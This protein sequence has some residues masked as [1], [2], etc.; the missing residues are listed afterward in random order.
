MVKRHRRPEDQVN[1][2]LS[3]IGAPPGEKRLVVQG[4]APWKGNRQDRNLLNRNQPS[5]KEVAEAL[6]KRVKERGYLDL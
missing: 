6:R 2:Y 3:P 5:K 4:A 1:V